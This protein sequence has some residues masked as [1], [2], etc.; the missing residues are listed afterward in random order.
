MTT[1]PGAPFPTAEL[2]DVSIVVVPAESVANV[3]EI[4]T[5]LTRVDLSPLLSIPLSV[6]QVMSLDPVRGATP[7]IQIESMKSQ[8]TASISSLRVEVHDLSGQWD[9]RSRAIPETMIRLLDELGITSLSAIGLNHE[10]TFRV[11]PGQTAA[12]SL[13]TGLFPEHS[14][15]LSDG[16]QFRGGAGRLYLSPDESTVV[17]IALEPRYGDPATDTI[18]LTQNTHVSTDQLPN[19]ESLHQTLASS[20]ETLVYTAQSVLS[21][22]VG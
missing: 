19:V 6:T 21:A 1:A 20:Y 9:F 12:Y 2:L 11:E 8:K 13:G 18:W 10:M 14:R 17:T 5:R 4:V 3:T 22:S 15:W 16:M 7:A